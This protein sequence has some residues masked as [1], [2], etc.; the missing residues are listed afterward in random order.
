MDIGVIGIGNMGLHLA[1]RAAEGGHRVRGFDPRPDAEQR[2]RA[3]G[4]SAA[5]SP[6]ELA[7]LSDV[8]ILMVLDD[9]QAEAAIWG[10]GGFA[11]GVHGE[12]ILLS[13]SSLSPAFMT[14]MAER[15]RGRFNVVDAPV[16]GGVEGAE[17][18]TLTIMVAAAEAPAAAVAPV[19]GLLGSSVV[20]VGDRPGLGC[21]MKAINQAM[22]FTA[23]ASA[24][25]MVV[26]GTRAGL[27]PD[28]IVGVIERSSGASWALG[29]R[30][31]LAWRADYASG[32]S[33]AIAEKDLRAALELAANLGTYSGVTLAAA[34]LVEDAMRAHGGAGDDP[35]IVEAVERLSGMR[36]GGSVSAS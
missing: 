18:G 14:E 33:L 20:R 5:A 7:A 16:S 10:E 4:A 17:R 15:A 2:L 8:V 6:A 22:Y 27:D 13:M 12:S 30:V 32:G 24:A 21:T 28:T 9:R 19:L 11:A 36:I 23:F 35:L 1:R 34:D 29:H 31:P 3:I 25:E 26:A